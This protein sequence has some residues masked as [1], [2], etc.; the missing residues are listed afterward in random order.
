MGAGE[1]LRLG[2]GQM[3]GGGARGERNARMDPSTA[4][5]MG[6]AAAV[7]TSTAGAGAHRRRTV[8]DGVDEVSL[9]LRCC[10]ESTQVVQ[11]CLKPARPRVGRELHRVYVLLSPSY[12][13]SLEVKRAGSENP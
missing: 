4:S 13:G 5:L 11:E 3:P 9:R 6:A 8:Q 7:H 10:L 2:L 12:S 1:R